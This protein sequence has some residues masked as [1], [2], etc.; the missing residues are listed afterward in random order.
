M[1]EELIEFDLFIYVRKNKMHQYA[2]NRYK[3]KK[4]E[5]EFFEF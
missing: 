1:I 2:Y 4:L 3:F 5:I